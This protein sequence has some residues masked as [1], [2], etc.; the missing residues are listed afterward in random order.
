KLAAAVEH[1]D[2]VAPLVRHI[3]VVVVVDRDTHR[4]GRVVVALAVFKEVGEMLF[5]TRSAELHLVA[6]HPEIVFA[7]PVGGVQDAAFAEAHRLDIVEAGATR[8]AAPD[9]MA[10]VKDP[11]TRDRCQ[12]HGFLH[13]ITYSPAGFPAAVRALLVVTGPP[14]GWPGGRAVAAGLSSSDRPALR[15]CR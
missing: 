15:T 7:A 1:V 3:D 5:F 9:G 11:S 14:A 13:S 8:R 10:P 12:R 4:P 2:R 6:V